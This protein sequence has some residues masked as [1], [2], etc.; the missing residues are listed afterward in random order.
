MKG[1]SMP[2]KRKS[3][4]ATFKAQVALAAL[5][6]DKTVHELASLHGVHPT[7]I[8]TWKKQLLDNAEEIFHSGAAT[9]SAA[10]EALQA[11]LYEEVCR[12]QSELDCLKKK[13]GPLWL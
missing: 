1:V 7:M 9:S 8:H 13:G 2:R 11:Q 4:T 5:K 6:G 3:H 12:L 10:H